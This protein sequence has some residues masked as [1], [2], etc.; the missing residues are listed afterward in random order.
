MKTVFISWVVQAGSETVLTPTMKSLKSRN[1][2][3]SFFINSK[4]YKINSQFLIKLQIHII[5]AYLYIYN[6]Q[7]HTSQR[8]FESTAQEVNEGILKTL[9][10][11]LFLHVLYPSKQRYLKTPQHH[12]NPHQERGEVYQTQWHHCVYIVFLKKNTTN[13]IEKLEKEKNICRFLC[14][15][16]FFFCCCC[17][18]LNNKWVKNLA[19]GYNI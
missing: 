8:A 14:F 18:W 11:V 17:C 13:S 19:Y 15:L 4:I 3:F 16:K 9:Q 1:P 6:L 2:R 10:F 12:L 7:H 5:Y